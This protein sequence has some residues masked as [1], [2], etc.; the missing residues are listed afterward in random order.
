MVGMIFQI[1]PNLGSGGAERIVADLS[2][3]LTS[4]GFNL[5]I[6]CLYGSENTI[7]ENELIKNKIQIIYLNKRRGPDFRI[8]IK[9]YKL[10]NDYR[11]DVVHSHLYVLRYLLPSFLLCK[12]PVKIHTIHNLANK[13]VDR[14]GKIFNK[15]SF[16]LGVKPVSISRKVTKSL[17][18]VYGFK[19]PVLIPNGIQLNKFTN[20]C[21]SKKEWREKEKFGLNEILF[22]CI[23]RFNVQ[24]NHKNLLKSF[25]EH[26]SVFSESKLVLVGDGPLKDDLLA[27]ATS[28]EIQT[29]VCFIGTRKDVCEILN[30][31][32]VFVLASDW[33]GNPLS[34]MEAMA[35][36]LP[37][38]CTAV[39]GVPEL[40]EN[41]V[42]G[43]TTLP[44]DTSQFARAMNLLASDNDLRLSLGEAASKYSVGSFGVDRMVDSYRSLYDKVLLDGE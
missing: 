15:L 12:I 40:I 29:R 41:E 25:S 43:I 6:I 35:S 44:G 22:V 26:C 42:T 33:E 1:I 9:I 10:I 32:D 20:P 13:E 14:V 21:V 3:G 19:S 7:I 39:G 4:R 18:D 30:A 8:F 27:Q 23:A 24:K 37:V 17:F 11:P 16:L 36:G 2:L 5:L 28:L 38:I 31:S 34:V